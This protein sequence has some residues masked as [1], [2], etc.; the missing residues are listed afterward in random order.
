MRK[1]SLLAFSLLLILA[2]APALAALVLSAP[3]LAAAPQWAPLGPYGGLVNTVTVDPA[4]NRVLYATADFQGTFKSADGGA[5]WVPIH[6]GYASGNVAV[7]PPGTR[8]STRHSIS[9]RC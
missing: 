5:S 4:D 9:T 1:L 3:S 6:T 8:R 7:D 2:A